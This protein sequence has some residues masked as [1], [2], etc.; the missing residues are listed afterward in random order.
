MICTV[1]CG[2]GAAIGMA[3]IP[4]RHR[5]IPKVHHRG[6][7]ACFVAVAGT[8]MRAIAGRRTAITALQTTAP[9]LLA[10]AWSPPSK[11]W[12]ILSF[13][14][15]LPCEIRSKFH[16]AKELCQ[17]GVRDEQPKGKAN[18]NRF[19]A[20]S[21]VLEIEQRF[22]Q[23]EKGAYWSFCVRYLNGGKI[24][25]FRKFWRILIGTNHV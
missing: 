16:G 9:T 25:M 20:A 8:T 7:T 23:N 4:H 18:M 15:R 19:L 5:P 22:Y 21:R 1:M 3:I 17:K 24:K 10:S 2:N 6:R 13:L 14:L 11:Q 12:L